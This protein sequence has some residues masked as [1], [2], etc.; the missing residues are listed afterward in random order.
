MIWQTQID[1]IMIKKILQSIIEY[2]TINSYRNAS[3]NIDTVSSSFDL[4]L[5]SGN[6]FIIVPLLVQNLFLSGS[7]FVTTDPCPSIHKV[8][9]P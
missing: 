1:M 4:V 5:M 6:R 2:Y 9:L 3:L 7:S 8:I